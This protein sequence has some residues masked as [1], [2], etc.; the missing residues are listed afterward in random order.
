METRVEPSVAAEERQVPSPWVWFTE[1]VGSGRPLSDLGLK[2][3]DLDIC[4]AQKF[5]E[6]QKFQFQA[7][8]QDPN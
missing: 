7:C 8:E 4:E 1:I 3:R 5:V 2:T 6:I